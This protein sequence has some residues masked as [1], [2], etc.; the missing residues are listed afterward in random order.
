MRDTTNLTARKYDM[1]DAIALLDVNQYP[2]L[3][4]LTNAGKD[5][6]TKKGKSFK[7]EATTDAEFK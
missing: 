4:I 3:A 2:M 6:V 7:K 1:A 5:P